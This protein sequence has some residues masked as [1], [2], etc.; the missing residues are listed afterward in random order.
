M[1]KIDRT[2]INVYVSTKEQIDKIKEENFYKNM[3][4]C[5]SSICKFIIVNKLN[6]RTIYAEEDNAIFRSD[7][8]MYFEDLRR[9]LDNR[10][11]SMRKFWGAMEKSYFKPLLSNLDIK[12][13]IEANDLVPPNAPNNVLKSEPLDSEKNTADIQE[14]RQLNSKIDNLKKANKEINDLYDI[15]KEKLNYL[16]NNV[17][18]TSSMTGKD[19]VEINMSKE[20]WFKFK[21]SIPNL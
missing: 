11:Q 1:A 12:N 7:L 19:Y 4:D 10:D 9:F 15:Y 16:I 17:K 13:T 8:R 5:I 6:P 2:T 3:D 21:N 20:E 14:L 18:I